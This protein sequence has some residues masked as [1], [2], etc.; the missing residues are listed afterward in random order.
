MFKTYFSAILFFGLIVMSCHV[1]IPSHDMTII[2]NTADS[3][4][5]EISEYKS[6]K[7]GIRNMAFEKVTDS[8]TNI[9]KDT[10]MG[11]VL[12]PL[13]TIHPGKLD[14]TWKQFAAKKGG[15]TFLFYKRNIEKMPPQQF[16]TQKDIFKRIDLTKRQLDS[17]QYV[18][19]LN[20]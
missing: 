14:T 12:K 8:R 16:L 18:V 3:V 11:W 20:N 15:L 13:D 17:L 7:D 5:F 2:N 19:K 1:S 9:T 4:Y 6:V 10:L